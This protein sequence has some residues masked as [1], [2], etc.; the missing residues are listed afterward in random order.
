MFTISEL[1]T[2][3]THDQQTDDD[4]DGPV[5]L[6]NIFHV[7]PGEGDDLTALWGDIIRQFK[8]QPGYISAQFHRGIAG[9][10]TDPEWGGRVDPAAG[11]WFPRQ[12]LQLARL[13]KPPLLP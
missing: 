7:E 6:V 9:S 10:D 12:G 5:V 3:V 1:D 13:A 8:N 2:H 4:T 11:D